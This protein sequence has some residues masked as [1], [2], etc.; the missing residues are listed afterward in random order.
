MNMIEAARQ[1]T[2]DKVRCILR[3][4]M[5]DSLRGEYDA[6]ISIGALHHMPPQ[7]ALRRLAAALRPGGVLAVIALPRHDL[8]RELP[9]ETI[10]AGHRLLGATFLV[11]RSAGSGSWFAKDPTHV[12]MPV[13]MD[14]P[15]STREVRQQPGAVLPGVRVRRLVFWRYLLLWHKPDNETGW[16]GA[17]P[18]APRTPA[19]R[20]STEAAWIVE[21]VQGA[22]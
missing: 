9:M 22:R 18:P 8:R 10:A 5:I 6:I 12:S 15:L 14:P 7:D 20:T 17:R 11:A 13:V 21:R 1:R 4:L 2:P 19:D 16:N 3:D